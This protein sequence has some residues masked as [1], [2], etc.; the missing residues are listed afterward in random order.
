MKPELQPGHTYT[1]RYTV[2]A[3]RTVPNLLPEAPGFA[4]MP[5][6]LATGYM[7]GILEWACVES[8]QEFLEEN[9]LTLGTH[10]DFSHKAPTV[11][12]ST[13]TIDVTVTKVSGRS[14]E[15]EIR[16]RDDYAEI[17]TGTHRRGVVPRDAFIAALPS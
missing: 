9:E 6:V 5:E 3:N 17:S 14:L 4:D 15:F 2:P 10:V 7:V 1:M 12:G 11:P 8:I 13:V 16:A